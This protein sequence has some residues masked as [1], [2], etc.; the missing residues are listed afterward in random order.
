MPGYSHSPRN[1]TSL[2][3]GKVSDTGRETG[4]TVQPLKYPERPW[5]GSEPRIKYLFCIFDIADLLT[6]DLRQGRSDI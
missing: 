4:N 5:V 6:A 1:E 3:D 2:H